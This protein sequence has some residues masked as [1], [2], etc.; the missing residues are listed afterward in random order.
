MTINISLLSTILQVGLTVMMTWIESKWL[1]ESALS[2]LMT[3]LTANNKWIP[4]IH[5]I[6]RRDCNFNINY[7]ELAIQIPFFSHALGFYSK[8]KF[9]FSDVTLQYMLN[10][11]KL[12]SS[13]LAGQKL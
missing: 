11:L 10:E 12:W 4:Y 5:K 3:K 1:K 7:G 6:T 2:Y 8:T 13:E 9:E